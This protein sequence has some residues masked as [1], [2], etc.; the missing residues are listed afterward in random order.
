[1]A[2]DIDVNLVDCE[3]GQC[4]K[5]CVEVASESAPGTAS[6]STLNE[7]RAAMTELHAAMLQISFAFPPPDARELHAVIDELHVVMLQV[8][9][10]DCGIGTACA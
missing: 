7:L 10:R 3:F 5:Q 4:A 6:Y 1:M 2:T 8:S 9:F